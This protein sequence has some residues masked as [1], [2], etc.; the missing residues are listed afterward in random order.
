MHSDLSG[1][2]GLHHFHFGIL[3]V[4]TE[5]SAVTERLTAEGDQQSEYKSVKWY[6]FD[7]KRRE[8]TWQNIL[9]SGT[10]A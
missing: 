8:L 1:P 4:V 10:A 5:R 2:Y 6:D 9:Y 7:R 3:H